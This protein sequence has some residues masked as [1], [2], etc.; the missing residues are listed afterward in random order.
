MVNPLSEAKIKITSELTNLKATKPRKF[1]ST[2][3]AINRQLLTLAIHDK[4]L[5]TFE[6]YLPKMFHDIPICEKYDEQWP[7]F[8]DGLMANCKNEGHYRKGLIYILKCIQKG[9]ISGIWQLDLPTIPLEIERAELPYDETWFAKSQICAQFYQH[10][11]NTIEHD[12]RTHYSAELLLAD[13]LLSAVFHSGIHNPKLL[14]VLAQSVAKKSALWADEDQIWI[15]CEHTDCA[16]NFIDDKDVS[17]L[18]LRLFLSWPTLG[19]IYRW[20]RN[21]KFTFSVP[22]TFEMF[23]HW[24]NR[25]LIQSKFERIN[26]SKLCRYS[27]LCVQ[28]HPG[29]FYPQVLS[30]VATNKLTSVGI[31]HTNWHELH[32]P[33]MPTTSCTGSVG[34][35]CKS[36]EKRKRNRSNNRI[37]RHSLFLTQLRSAIAEK[38]SATQKN[39]R[40]RASKALAAIYDSLPLTQAEQILLGWLHRGSVVNKNQPS[41]LRTYLSSGGIPWLNLCYGEDIHRWSGDDFVAKYREILNIDKSSAEQVKN[42]DELDDAAPKYAKGVTYVA[43][44]LT[45][46]HKYGVAVYGLEPLSENLIGGVREKPHIRAAY[47]SEPL[48][49]NM[50]NILQQTPSLTWRDKQIL[51]CIAILAFRSGLRLGELVKLRVID[52]DISD[53]LWIYVRSTQLDN[54]KTDSAHRKMPL[55]VLLTEKEYEVVNHYFSSRFQAKTRS[56]A[57]LMFPSNAGELIPLPDNDVSSPIQMALNACSKQ[58][59]TFHHLRHTAISRLQLLLHRDAL[60]L[61]SANSQLGLHLMPWDEARCM[62][63]YNAVMSGHPR[64]DYWALAQFAGHL[65][66]ETT[67]Q[68]YLHF[69]DWVS[70]ACLRQAQYDWGSKARCYFAGL[71]VRQLK[72]LDWFDGPLTYRQC[73]QTIRDRLSGYIKKIDCKPIELPPIK[74]AK[75][76]KLDIFAIQQILIAITRN[77]EFLDLLTYYRLTDSE[78]EQWLKKIDALKLLKTKQGRSRVFHPERINPVIPGELHSHAEEIDFEELVVKARYIYKSNRNG[79]IEWIKYQLMHANSQNHPLSFRSLEELTSYVSIVKELLPVNRITIELHCPDVDKKRWIAALPKKI[80]I[81]EINSCKGSRARLWIK[82]PE[83]DKIIQ[84]QM[85]RNKVVKKFNR[86]STPILHNLAFIISIRLFSVE[87]LLSWSPINY[88]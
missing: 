85:K 70:F 14:H 55:A 5:Q 9:N 37:D 26:V 58:Q 82:H 21:H 83:E 65:S 12:G 40:Q 84:E 7:R 27:Q 79:L 71:S 20:Y 11:M 72:I 30:H 76:P 74:Q 56:S 4:A 47:I 38:I 16:T 33:Y 32:Q 41:S 46:I 87:E 62:L 86:Y 50:L 22:K 75:T 31:P 43:E 59:W 42:A 57:A 1:S 2:K 17:R 35:T 81:I 36:V 29:V 10:W 39:T 60:E 23:E 3:R 54:T 63:I 53:E 77:E 24:L 13:L 66:P 69:C 68:S 52:V 51:V 45:S 49:R 18:Q 25:F 61:H 6:K 67:L 28:L 8:L 73:Y 78:I 64:G 48:F 34:L 44:R 80:N 15:E 88:K 19:L